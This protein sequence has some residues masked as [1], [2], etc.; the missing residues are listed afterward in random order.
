MPGICLTPTDRAALL[1]D[2]RRG[3]DPEVRLRA[4]IL[5]LLDA[6]HA[7]CVGTPLLSV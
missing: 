3:A 5:L 1:D 2:Y 7:A 6:G 4:H